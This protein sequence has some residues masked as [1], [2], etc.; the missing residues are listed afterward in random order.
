MNNERQTYGA[1]SKSAKTYLNVSEK[2]TF[3]RF[4]IFWFKKDSC[5]RGF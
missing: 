1:Y 3:L 5:V 4:K 2:R